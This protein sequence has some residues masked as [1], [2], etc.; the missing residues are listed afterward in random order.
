MR[1]VLFRVKGHFF[2]MKK[3]TFLIYNSFTINGTSISSF[4][5]PQCVDFLSAFSLDIYVPNF[6]IELPIE[7]AI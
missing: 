3:M 6:K 5:R 4:V 2:Q 7:I 1:I